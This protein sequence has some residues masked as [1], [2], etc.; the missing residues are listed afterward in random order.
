ML[1]K[2]EYLDGWVEHTCPAHGVLLVGPKNLNVFCGDKGQ[3]GARCNRLCEKT[4]GK[5]SKRK[6]EHDG[7]VS[8]GYTALLRYSSF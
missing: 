2:Q 8:L 5:F 1:T 3:V 4:Y 6:V 7:Y